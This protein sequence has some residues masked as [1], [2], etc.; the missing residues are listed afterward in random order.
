MQG[1]SRPILEP[2]CIY[3]SQGASPTSYGPISNPQLS[4][5]ETDG[6]TI[7]VPNSY[8]V[9]HRTMHGTRLQMQKYG[10][11]ISTTNPYKPCKQYNKTYSM[12]I[13]V[14]SLACA[15]TAV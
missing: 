4:T 1:H 15:R 11:M 3:E 7:S 14:V 5:S 12:N 13:F 9:L 8:V 6:A 10:L 2:S